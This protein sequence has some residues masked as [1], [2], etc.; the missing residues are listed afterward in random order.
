MSR[1]LSIIV[2]ALNEAR[3]IARLKD[4][5]DHLSNPDR[6]DIE[7][8]LIDGGSRDD[9][10]NLAKQA[11]FGKVI[12]LPGASIP[13]CRNRGVREA[14]G[15]WLAF[16]DADCEVAKDWLV[17]ASPFL[18][19]GNPVVI[20]WPVSPPEPPTWVQ[21]A[22]HYHWTH[23]NPRTELVNGHPVVKDQGFRLITTRNMLLHRSA[24]DQIGGFDEELSTGEDTDFVFRAYTQSIPV[25]GVPTLN[26][27]HHGEPATLGLFFRQQLWHANRA[28]YI[29]IERTTGGSLGGNAPRF[30]RLFLVSLVA[31]IL[32]PVGLIFSQGAVILILPLVLLVTGPAFFL[33]IRGGRPGFFP[34]LCLLYLAYGLARCI[35]LAGFHRNKSSWKKVDR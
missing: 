33:S 27:V 28:S 16:V 17:Q 29:R 26:V 13:V 12:R 31:F 21:A 24:Y 4:S 5:I 35:D 32:A 15:D 25:L 23:K 7:T 11:G 10:A 9:T 8:I 18:Q 2:V 3:H 6:I 20:G 14:K 34:A 1:V 19:S 30:T 22:W